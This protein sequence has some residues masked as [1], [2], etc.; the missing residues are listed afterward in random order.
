M[1]YRLSLTLT[2][3]DADG[4][5]LGRAATRDVHDVLGAD[6]DAEDCEAA[7]CRYACLEAV[8]AL[9]DVKAMQVARDT[10]D[11]KRRA[12]KPEDAP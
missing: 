9:R 4:H 7:L 3:V 6:L 1:R 8:D 12:S 10:D 2:E 11:E 5:A